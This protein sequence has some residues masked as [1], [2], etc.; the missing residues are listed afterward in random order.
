MG[1]SAQLGVLGGIPIIALFLA[2]A[3]CRPLFGWGYAGLL[4]LVPLEIVAGLIGIVLMFQ[5]AYTGLGI[6]T[7]LFVYALVLN[8]VI[9]LLTAVLAT[10]WSNASERRRTVATAPPYGVRG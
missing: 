10:V 7:A 8:F 2:W 1:F 3:L 4:V 5:L 6:Q 9:P